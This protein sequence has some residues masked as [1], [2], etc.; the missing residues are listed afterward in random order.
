MNIE[1]GSGLSVRAMLAEFRNRARAVGH[2]LV[3]EVLDDSTYLTVH[4]FED[5]AT[6]CYCGHASRPSA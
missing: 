4:H 1:A 5:G 6:L 3:V 2:C